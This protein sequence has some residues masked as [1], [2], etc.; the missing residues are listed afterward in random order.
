MCLLHSLSQQVSSWLRSKLLAKNMMLKVLFYSK[1]F[2]LCHMRQ[3]ESVC[4]R[5]TNPVHSALAAWVALLAHAGLRAED[6]Q[7]LKVG[8][9]GFTD[10]AI[11]GICR[12]PKPRGVSNM[13]WAALRCGV[14]D[15]DWGKL[16]WDKLLSICSRLQLD[17]V[18]P[19]V[20]G[21]FSS[22]N[23]SRWATKNEQVASLWFVL[24]HP[25]G[26]APVERGICTAVYAPFA[27]VLL[28]ISWIYFWLLS[29]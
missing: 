20:T 26:I 27:Q 2:Q 3:V 6:S 5:A 24:T 28:H 25:Q 13:P 19:G 12:N 29:F 7:R 11:H 9:C 21:D 16:A 15:E 1:P 14:F 22:L 17:F 4:V 18:L 23:W 10:V 8:S